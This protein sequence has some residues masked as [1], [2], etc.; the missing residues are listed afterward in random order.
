MLEEIHRARQSKQT[1]ISGLV[2]AR[3]FIA[4]AAIA[5]T[6]M[7]NGEIV[8]EETIVTAQKREQSLQDVPIAIAVVS[9]EKI[10]NLGLRN[11]QSMAQ[12]VPNFYQVATPTSNVVY[13]RGIGSGPNAGFEQSV[14]TF[15][16]GIYLGRARQTL[17]P[18]YDLQ[19]V[20]ILKGPQSILFGKN[21]AAGAISIS[22]NRPSHDFSARVSALYGTQNDRQLQ[23]Y[24][25]GSLGDSVAGRLALYGAGQDGWVKN[26]YSDRNGPESR[27][28]GVRGSLVFDPS[29][30]VSAYLKLAHSY[31]KVDGAPYEIF[32][33]SQA[34]QNGVLVPPQ[35]TDV[36]AR[37]NYR[38]NY[39]NSGVLGDN[40]TDSKRSF[41]D[42]VLQL[43]FLL[44]E[45]TLTSISGYTAYKMNS[46]ADLDATA[47]NVVNATDGSE[48]FS[49]WSQE[50]RLL[51]PQGGRFEY[52]G[53]LYWQRAQLEID[54]P[55]GLEISN[56]VPA[57]GLINAD[58]FRFATFDQTTDTASAFFQGTLGLAER[59]RLKLGLRYTYERKSLDRSIAVRDFDG[60]PMGPLGLE[61]VWRTRFSTVPY[62]AS[63]E[64]AESDWSPMLA[65][66]WDATDNTMNYL[67]L[68][69]GFKGGGYDS[70]HGNGN[71]LAALEYEPETTYSFELGSKMT[72]MNGRGNLN[73]AYFYTM[74]DDLQVSI[75]DGLGGF[76]VSN[77]ASATTQ[78]VELDTRWL[79]TRDFVVSASLAWLD[80]TYD[81]F[82]A[83]PCDN[84]Q[85]AQHIVDTGDSAGCIND[86]AGETVNYAPAYTAALSGI[87]TAHLSQSLDMVFTLDANY[88]HDY[89]LSAELDP[90][91]EQDA[92]WKI[93]ARIA[94]MALNGRWE[95][96][97]IGKNLTDA[98]TFSAG[99]AVPLATT[100]GPSWNIPDYKGTYMASVERP[101]NVALQFSYNFD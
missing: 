53:G 101:R 22:S 29:D 10:E 39:G 34:E 13:V 2:R 59:W 75:F 5:L 21:T 95:L 3:V 54:S 90:S 16:D 45:H 24:V 1:D 96:A 68:S 42:L 80:Y 19:R 32:Q 27:S 36:D 69:K 67:S 87:Y 20:E 40:T 26:E 35:L 31:N 79:L 62:E 4:S 61:L 38:T 57:A 43:D 9:G 8:L 73:L 86:L 81:E 88:R 98:A 7:V 74:I 50:L 66:E 33:K 51:S 30:T 65:L 15:K 25:N 83:A 17:A 78:G 49:Q 11:L 14:G 18:L 72:F 44:G 82:D 94:L 37:Q 89:N 6:G 100:N 47:V 58:G 41:D 99:S 71:D 63:P 70:T 91:L 12:Y 56:V 60:A 84:P 52:I 97:V 23:G 48:N 93:N 77:A 85:L 92:Y 64:L 46:N 76:S 28:Y 55:I